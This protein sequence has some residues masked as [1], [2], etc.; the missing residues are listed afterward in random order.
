MEG[1]IFETVHEF[2]GGKLKCRSNDLTQSF[3]TPKMKGLLS[4]KCW[5]TLTQTT[6]YH[7][8]EDSNLRDYI[9]F[10]HFYSTGNEDQYHPE[11][12]KGHYM[13]SQTT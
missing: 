5:E 7:I 11:C 3:Q 9:S 1:I 6:R 2:A 8:P 10:P 12:T 13:G 4:L